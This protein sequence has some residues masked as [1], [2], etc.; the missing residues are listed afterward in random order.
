TVCCMQSANM[1]KTPKTVMGWKVPPEASAVLMMPTNGR[2]PRFR[3]VGM[4]S[5]KA[6]LLDALGYLDGEE[7]EDGR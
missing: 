5:K 1:P 6:A 2:C 3:P 4:F 7:E